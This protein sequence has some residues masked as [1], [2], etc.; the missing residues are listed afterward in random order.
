MKSSDIRSTFLNYFEK[1]NHKIIH[2]SSL[3]PHNDPTLMFAN[4]GMVQ[5]KNVFTGKE[6]LNYNRAVTAQ[7]CVRAGGKHN[8]LENVG[9]TARHH[10]F[11]EMLGNFSFGDYFKD[12]AIEFAWNLITKEFGIDK[13]K[14]IVTVFSEDEDA[15]K[16][17]KKI[18]GLNNDKIIRINSS[19]NFWSMGDTGPCGP[20]SEIFYDHGDKYPGGPPGSKDEDGDRFIEIWNLVFMQFEQVSEAKRINLPKPSVD[21]G[22]GLERMSALLN[23]TNDNYNTDLFI[24][25][26]N[27]S[28]DLLNDESTSQSPSHRVIAD[29]LR[30]SSFLIADGVTPSNEGRGYVLRRIMRRG[31]RH[32]HSLGNKDTVFDKIFP[33]LLDI[34]K[35]SYPELLRAK[36]LV[37]NT[38]LNEESKFKETVEKGLKILEDEISLS[39][40]ILDGAIAFKL[41]DT[42]G[43]PLDLTQDYLKLKKIDVDIDS[44]NT[45]MKEQKDRAR[46]SWKGTGDKEDQ[47]KWFQIAESLSST[48]FLGYEQ[49][50]TESEIISIIK[51]DLKTENLLHEEEGIIILN[52]TPFYAESG[53][54]IGDSGKII[55]ENNIF[56]VFKTTKLFGSF[57]LHH[58]KVKSGN[59]AK[60]DNVSAIIDVSKRELIKCNHSSTHLLHSSL[61]KVLGNHIAQKGSLVNNEKLRFDFSHNESVS[62]DNML[63]IENQVKKE[64]KNNTEVITKIIDHQKAIDEGAIALF[65]EKYGDEVRVVSMGSIEDDVIFSKELCGGT[66]VNKTGDIKDFKIISQSSVASGIRR[67]EALTNNSVTK[68]NEQKLKSQKLKKEENQIKI[69]KLLVEIKKIDKDFSYPYDHIKDLSIIIKELRKKLELK[70]QNQNKEITSQN[71]INENINNINFVYLITDDYPAKLLKQFVDDQKNKYKEKCVSLIISRN[72]NKI[73]IVLG[74]TTDLTTNFDSSKIIQDLSIILGGNGGGGRK[75]LAQAGGVNLDNVNKVIDKIKDNLNF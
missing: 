47:A 13:N 31:M 54:Q 1:N 40:K 39:P 75:D 5:F 67:I 66:H 62:I 51:K 33:T 41:Y 37:L 49:I 20:C 61:R 30:S 23:G 58:G 16:Y 63:K 18:A 29:H 68:Y 50:E 2:S 56:E 24:P 17:W 10:T 46:Q 59:F 65:G 14:L 55:F 71:I 35:D 27:K 9:Y 6:K 8:D 52:Q 57:F 43:F 7:K 3:V 38:Y 22:M 42:Y 11:F 74:A 19:D 45:K 44:F 36:D 53:G 15:Y 12:N 32:A 70:K 34:F 60:G 48:E 26:I 69:N 28:I 73:S 4:S 21:T 72:N 64:I 25:L